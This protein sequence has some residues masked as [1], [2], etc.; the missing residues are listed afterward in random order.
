MYLY[1]R[2]VSMP[3]TTVARLKTFRKK[4]IKKKKKNVKTINQKDQRFLKMLYSL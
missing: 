2:Y 3:V 4:I 1:S